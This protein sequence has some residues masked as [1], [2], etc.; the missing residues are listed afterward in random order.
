MI[1]NVAMGFISTPISGSKTEPNTSVWCSCITVQP[2]FVSLDLGKLE[3]TCGLVLSVYAS[4][5]HLD[6]PFIA[7]ACLDLRE[8]DKSYF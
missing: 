6:L 2:I 3:T 7:L 8:P 4:C 1:I 5:I